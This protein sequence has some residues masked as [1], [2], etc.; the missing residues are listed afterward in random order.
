MYRLRSGIGQLPGE[1]LPVVSSVLTPTVMGDYPGYC[2]WLPF[3][4]YLPA[5]QVPTAAAQNAAAGQ[6]ITKAAGVDQALADEQYQAYLSDTAALA[7]LDPEGAAQYTFAGQ[8]PN[9]AALLG[10]GP[11]GR[12][13]G[14][15]VNAASSVTG[16]LGVPT[17]V[18]LLGS[19]G[20]FGVVALGGG[21]PRRY[22]R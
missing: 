14:S 13:V 20:A 15:A 2:G 19:L 3:S 1:T 10:A 5:C 4:D 22:G 17:W 11:F 12:V 18:W 16:W 7:K 21:S 8:N 6:M 9:E